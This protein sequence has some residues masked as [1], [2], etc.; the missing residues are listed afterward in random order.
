M[1]L[2]DG[3]IAIVTGAGSGLGRE[4][5]LALAAH[6]ATVVVNDLDEAGAAETVKAITAAGGHADAFIGSVSDWDRA[7]AMV[8]H[9]IETH[10]DLHILVNNAGFTRDAMSFSM[11][12]EQFDQVVNVHLKGH[13]APM[14]HTVTYWRNQAKA[15]DEQA[16]RII[17]TTS[18]SGL[19]G[20]AGQ[21]NYGAAKGGIITMSIAIARE[22]QKYGVTVNVIAP[23]ARTGITAE[24]HW[25][26]PPEDPAEF[27][28]F[29]PGNASPL[30]VWL[31][32]DDAAH[33]NGQ[34]FIVGSGVVVRMKRHSAIG[35]IRKDGR[36]TPE[37]L[38]ARADELL[39]GWDP[40][41]PA[42]EAPQF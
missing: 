18:E 29:H 6:G 5:A 2:L 4:H 13:F 11:T 10:G 38:T 17:N 28:R 32:S 3:R 8:Q 19:F 36:W 39:A 14:H 24:A 7:G 21:T 12:E 9:A 42:F 1:S 40:G 33:V 37:E 16:R 20:G 26:Q 30:V 31:A 15:G 41:V 27:D 35:E 23:R 34:T 22:T 25:A